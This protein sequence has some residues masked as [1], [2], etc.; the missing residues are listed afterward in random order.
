MEII[1]RVIDKH[2]EFMEK[3]DGNSFIEEFIPETMLQTDRSSIH[4]DIKHW[5]PIKS[6]I[7]TLEIEALEKYFG[8][9]LP[10]SYKYFLSHRHFIELDLGQVSFFKNLP[11]TIV[12]DTKEEVG[13]FFQDLIDRRYIPFA[14]LVDFG[15]VCFD[16][17]KNLSNEDYKIVSFDT[18]D[19]DKAAPFSENFESMFVEFETQLDAWIA[20]KRAQ[21]RI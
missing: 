6:T 16:A 12:E 21:K 18:Y 4:V 2:F 17:N 8:S 15:V 11:N 5:I 20:N 13:E 9:G 10:I 1:K 19:L 14:R 3:L 7:T